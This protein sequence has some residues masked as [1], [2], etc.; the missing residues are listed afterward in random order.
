MLLVVGIR[1]GFLPVGKSALEMVDP[2]WL[3][4]M[5]F[6][7]AALFFLAALAKAT[8]ATAAGHARQGSG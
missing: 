2:Y 7:T 1:G 5:R 4:T 6:R 8:A 3:T